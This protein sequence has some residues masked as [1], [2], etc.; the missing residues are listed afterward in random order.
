ME[1]QIERPQKRQKQFFS[2]KQREHTLKTQVIIEKKT[3]K[4]ICLENNKGRIHDFRIFKA[5]GVRFSESVK[6]R[7]SRTLLVK[8]IVIARIAMRLRIAILA[9]S[10]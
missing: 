8:L 6:V 3:L 10:Y 2:G 7:F 5:S 4:I 9:P 1:S